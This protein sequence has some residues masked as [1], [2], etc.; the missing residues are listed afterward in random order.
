[1]TDAQ[2]IRCLKLYLLKG[3]HPDIDGHA[4]SRT[5][6]MAED[7]RQL[8]EQTDAQLDEELRGFGFEP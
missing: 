2:C 8:P 5:R 7:P 3:L 6:H 4:N 1:M